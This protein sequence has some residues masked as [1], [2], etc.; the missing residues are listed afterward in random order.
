MRAASNTVNAWTQSYVAV[1]LRNLQLWAARLNVWFVQ[2]ILQLHM[3]EDGEDDHVSQL[4]TDYKMEMQFMLQ[5]AADSI[6][7]F[8][9]QLWAKK[10][11]LRLQQVVKVP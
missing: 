3:N 10:D 2:A 8:N 6:N 11:D 5:N 1:T 7:S 4:P 9:D